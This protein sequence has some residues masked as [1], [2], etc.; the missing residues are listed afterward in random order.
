MKDI[1][2]ITN[3]TPMTTSLK[4]AEVFEKRPD[5]VCRDIAIIQN[6]LKSLGEHEL[7]FEGVEII[8]KNAI[9]GE[10]KEKYYL[11]DR[12]A[13][14]ILAFGFTGAKA[15]KFKLDFL[16][17]FNEMELELMKTKAQLIDPSDLPLTLE[18]LATHLRKKEET[19]WLNVSPQNKI[20]KIPSHKYKRTFSPRNMDTD[21]MTNT[22]PKLGFKP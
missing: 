10:Y 1:V 14:S 20:K 2:T 13:F 18:T 4:V 3:N 17:A 12:D 16:K 15:L 22:L 21:S 6:T 11:M 19:N 8:K 9:G 7:N 5:N